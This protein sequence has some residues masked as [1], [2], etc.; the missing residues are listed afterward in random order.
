[1]TP[2]QP[3]PRPG[4]L[5]DLSDRVV[6]VTGGDG[7]IGSGLVRR[8]AQTG[9]AVV[10]HHLDDDTRARGLAAE[11]VAGGGRAT[12]ARGDIRD[13]DQ[14]R[15]VVRAAVDAFGHLDTL[16]NNAGVQPLQALEDMT[17]ADW[18]FVVQVNLTG[19]FAMTQAATEAMKVQ[20]EPGGSITH[21]ASVE[22]SLPAPNH[23]HYAAAKAAVKMHARSAA[24]ELGKYGIRVNTVSPGLID[25]GD[26]A[27][28]WPAG[29]DSWLARAP[30]ARTG[31]PQDIADA[32]I[33]LASPLASWVSGHDL[34]VDGAMSSVPAW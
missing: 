26:L 19:T 18:D 11:V 32:C 17:V 4:H 34:V 25:R 2:P 20:R 29:R 30:L 10:V 21:I 23:A 8:F 15:A 16:V 12:T 27:E 9:A 28:S 14:C 7:G 1:M 5:P 13:L 24:M 22:A 31:T 6:L 3:T 33:F